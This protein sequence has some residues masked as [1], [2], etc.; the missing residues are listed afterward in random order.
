M[1]ELQS[2]LTHEQ[3][4]NNEPLVCSYSTNDI[5]ELQFAF[6]HT[7]NP[8]FN[9]L[10]PRPTHTHP[11][12]HDNLNNDSTQNDGSTSITTPTKELL[13]DDDNDDNNNNDG[14]LIIQ[15]PDVYIDIINAVTFKLQIQSDE[16]SAAL[17]YLKQTVNRNTK[18]F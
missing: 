1:L 13:N 8:V 10:F 6:G 14:N 3:P 4:N 11:G 17:Q 12:S 2:C 5:K 15:L 16:V 9:N 7:E 18:N